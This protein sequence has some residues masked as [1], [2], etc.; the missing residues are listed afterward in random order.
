LRELKGNA[1]IPWIVMGD[2]NEIA[3]SHEKEGGNR[4]P[5]NYMRAFRDALADC[6]LED[7]GYI[8]D[9]FTW[10]RER[11]RA[12]LDKAV[13][14]GD[15]ITM[16]PGAILQHLQWTKSDH[17]PI[18]LDT[19]Y[20]PL[21]SLKKNGPKQFEEKWLKENQFRQEVVQAWEAANLGNDDGVL[22]CLGRMHTSLHAW[23]NRILKKPKGRLRKA[24][25]ELQKALDGPMTDENEVIAKSKLT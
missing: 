11:I 16:H 12:R 23:D 19:N 21:A 2:F 1:D 3:F 25:H 17:R 9:P 6:D 10:R 18:L 8:G 22:A 20:E 15:R 4:R 14:T 13:A 7:I 24:Q 5:Q